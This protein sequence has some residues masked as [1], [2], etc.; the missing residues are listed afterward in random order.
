M[1]GHAGDAPSSW[2]VRFAPA[3]VPGGAV[4]DVACGRG[5]HAR[6]LEARGHRVTGID[7]DA[8]AL[9]ASGASETIAF[10]L[11]AGAAW[12][13]AGRRFAAVLVTNYLHRPLFPALIAA[14]ADD[15][16]LIVETFAVGQARFGR[17]SNPAFLLRPNELLDACRSL[18]VV[19]YEDGLLGAP[20]RASIQRI[21]AAM[22]TADAAAVRRHALSPEHVPARPKSAKIANPDFSVGEAHVAPCARRGPRRRTGRAVAARPDPS[23]SSQAAQ[24]A[25]DAQPEGAS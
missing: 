25:T 17:P 6:F 11:E 10:D 22:R 24:A 7:R 15:G 2:V 20:P 1:S 19:A 18:D 5:R 12:P 3:I 21:V 8:D 23:S 16:L 4:L 9:A 13:L 14:L